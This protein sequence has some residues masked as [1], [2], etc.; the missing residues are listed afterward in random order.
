MLITQPAVVGGSTEPN[1]VRSPSVESWTIRHYGTDDTPPV[2]AR[3][4]LSD[5]QGSCVATPTS[6]DSGATG[7]CLRRIL[8][9]ALPRWAEVMAV[10]PGHARP[11]QVMVSAARGWRLR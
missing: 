8:T 7:C 5:P 1:L 3:V 9:T 4:P 6:A 11:C 10:L 2:V